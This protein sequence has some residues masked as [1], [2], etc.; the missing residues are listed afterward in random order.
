MKRTSDS[1]KTDSD[2]ND[3]VGGI[4]NTLSG[5][6]NNLGKMTDVGECFPKRDMPKE[7][8]W[9]K[10]NHDG[11]K[12]GGES[13]LCRILSG[14]TEIAEKLSEISEKGETATKKGEFN[15]NS[16]EGGMKGGYGFTLK[17]ALGAKGDEVRVEPFGNIRKD[18]KTGEATVQEIHE[19][20]IDVFEDKD[21]T[22]LIAEMP[23]VG[24]GDIKTELRFDVLTIS[25][26]KGEKKYRK[27]VLLTH[28]SSKERIKVTC[29][30]GIV[31][32]RC[33]KAD[34]VNR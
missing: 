19:P 25:A 34:L 2:Q 26:E 11:E 7:G 3:V 21:A 16:K 9:D 33:E 29:N 24:I 17:T 5:F 13:K 22:T 28:A 14:L 23:G 1:K 6:I 32:I 10:N 15:F 12:D 31:T 18:K 8:A 20:L 30:N 4:F 27:E